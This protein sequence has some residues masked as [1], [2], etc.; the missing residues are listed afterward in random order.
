M[1]SFLGVSGGKSY[2]LGVKNKCLISF[3]TSAAL[4]SILQSC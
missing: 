4:V 3:F 2:D 1:G